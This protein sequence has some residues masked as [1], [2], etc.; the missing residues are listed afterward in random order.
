MTSIVWLPEAKDDLQRLFEFIQPHSLDAA[1][2]AIDTLINAAETLKQFPDKG[3][4][5]SVAPEFRELFVQFGARG[6][7]IRYRKMQSQIIIVRVW[8]TLE[9]R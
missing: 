9:D 7:V 6:Y 2:R 5:W 1:V 3:R 4:P 8:H